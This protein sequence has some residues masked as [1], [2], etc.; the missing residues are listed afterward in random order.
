M[1]CGE[2]GQELQ[3]QAAVREARKR[4]GAL[5][6]H[7]WPRVRSLVVD[8]LW[9]LFCLDGEREVE[10]GNDK[11]SVLRGVDWGRADKAAV[12]ALVGELGLV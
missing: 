9:G 12:K 11:A 6:L 5:M 7:P 10:S 4:L 8:E 1:D 2:E 3:L